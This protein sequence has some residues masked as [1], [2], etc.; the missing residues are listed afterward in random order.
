MLTQNFEAAMQPFLV[1]S[2][3][4]SSQ[5]LYIQDGLLYVDDRFFQS[6]RRW[7]KESRFTVLTFLAVAAEKLIE[8]L[9]AYQTSSCFHPTKTSQPELTKSMIDNLTKLTALRASIEA[10]FALYKTYPPYAGD[11]EFRETA[12]RLDVNLSKLF[13]SATKMKE[14]FH[15]QERNPSRR[16]LFRHK[17]ERAQNFAP[18]A[19][20]S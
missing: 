6:A 4:K 17:W 11:A 16:P 1:L 7:G 15:K 10:G 8:I 9:L 20:P 14:R 5:R 18:D 12:E 2:T 3:L 19:V 13:S